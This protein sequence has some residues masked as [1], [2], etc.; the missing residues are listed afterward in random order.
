MSQSAHTSTHPVLR[1]AAEV[2]DALDAVTEVSAT[3]L[4]TETKRLALLMLSR[5]AHRLQALML[6]VM[7]AS[8]DV[9]AESG[10]RS[11]A[12]WLAHEM[13]LDG[14]EARRLERLA[15]GMERHAA[16]ATALGAGDL[17]PGQAEVI[18]RALDDLPAEVTP[19]VRAEA[20][21]T[22]VEHAADLDPRGLRILGRRILEVVAPG[23][24]DEHERR[25]L[26]A[27]EHRARAAAQITTRRL[28][29][30]LSR[31]VVDLPDS[32]MDVWVSQLQ[33]YAS[34]R[35]AHLADVA[36]RDPASGERVPYARR[37]AQ[38]FA[39][40]I[41]HLPTEALPQHG[42]TSVSV[43]VNVDLADLVGGL[44]VAEL[45]TGERLSA[46]EVRRL[47]CN[48]S[49][50]PVVLGGASEILDLGRGQR[51]FSPAQRRAMARRD[52]GCRAEGCDI[53]AAWTEAHHL[54]PWSRG[55]RTDLADGLLLCSFHHH[56]AHDRGYESS[57]LPNGDVRFH[58][59]V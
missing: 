32:T 28:G 3:Y 31:A 20:E 23:V 8:D 9:A 18:A 39:T 35:R 27:D 45:S 15:D 33:A 30:G 38:A 17:A 16:V 51:L 54:Q 26:E 29:G 56:R 58:R 13:R 22:L 53:P 50:V 6:R 4:T 49:I 48:A 47:A 2:R 37:L 19:A 1:C 42:G 21:R 36:W 24:A 44:G 40:M 34:P 46:G 55:G 41:E 7:A 25:L 12:A 57:R 59:R 10:A 11:P 5:E 14:A 52:G 43:L